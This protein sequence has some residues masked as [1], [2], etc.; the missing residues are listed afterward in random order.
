MS[1][2]T[3][4][5]TGSFT[6]GVDQLS[7]VNSANVTTIFDT[8]T[9]ILSLSGTKSLAAYQTMLRSVAFQN[10][11]N[12]FSTPT[13]TIQFTATD[14]AGNLSAPVLRTIGLSDASF[15]PALRDIE[16]APLIYR[17]GDPAVPLTTTVAVTDPDSNYVTAASIWISA[18]YQIGQ[19]VLGFANTP[20]L[21][22]SWNPATGTLT[23]TGVDTVS[24][25]R[26][27]LRNVLFQ[28]PNA[29]P[30][31]LLRTVS[32]RVSDLSSGTLGS[33]IVTRNVSPT[34]NAPSVLRDIESTPLSYKGNDPAT[35][36]TATLAVTDP[37]SD[38]LTS[39]TIRITTNYQ[40]NQ[41]ILS[42]ANTATLTSSWD[43]VAGTLTISGVD[44]VSRYRTELRNVMYRN[45]SSTPTLLPRTV[46]I[47][48]SDLFSGVADSNLVTRN[49][50]LTFGAR[51]VLGSV[52]TVV[53]FSKNDDP[54]VIAPS[55]TVS[56]ADSVNLSGATIQITGS[57]VTGQDQLSFVNSASVTS[58]FDPA[59]GTLTLS[60]TKSLAAYQTM[61]QSV[62]FKNLQN[63]YSTAT[64]SI[65]FVVIDESGN[66]SNPLTRLISLSDAAFPPVLRDLESTALDYKTGDAASAPTS[67]LAV[68]DPVSN[69][70]TSATIRISTN[71]QNGQ[72]LLS[73]ANTP[74]LSATWDSSAGTLRITGVDTVSN[75]RSALRNVK[76]QNTSATPSL[77]TRTVSFQVSDLSSAA[78][79]SNLVSRSLIIR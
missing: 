30:S 5:I 61:L 77:L 78:S 10:S 19:D 16:T 33:N 23:I 46:S 3:I 47:Q 56:D 18:N 69:F 59:S 53:V 24:N 34:G 60:G 54:A 74:T 55:L 72:D 71:Y 64:R 39:A 63:G 52:A 48:V 1:G 42:F 57:Y 51:P 32:F 45:S 21:T 17:G 36:L 58:S 66:S 75:Y 76:Y 67:I 43:A 28:N 6:S 25:Y 7:F 8:T 26:T 13:R 14:E 11:L 9:G 62:A 65:Q 15:P 44:T 29:T 20:T 4:Q 2:A 12:S 49:V 68:T 37:D 22:G 27:A 40:S 35:P 70:L 41:D 50:T 38:Y 73:F 79:D 31:L